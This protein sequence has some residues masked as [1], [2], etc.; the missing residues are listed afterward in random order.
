MVWLHVYTILALMTRGSALLDPFCDNTC[1]EFQDHFATLG[2]A[3]NTTLKQ[4]KKACRNEIKLVHPD[5]Q[6]GKSEEE[7]RKMNIRHLAVSEACQGL[8]THKRHDEVG[9]ETLSGSEVF[10]EKPLF[11]FFSLFRTPPSPE[12]FCFVLGVVRV[13]LS[14]CC[15][16]CSAPPFEDE[17]V[18]LLKLCRVC[19]KDRG[20][21]GGDGWD[22]MGGLGGLG[23]MV[24]IKPL[25][26]GCSSQMFHWSQGLHHLPDVNT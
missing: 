20:E 1:P 5:K 12:L 6:V 14:L 2:V 24:R 26:L 8:G 13:S 10:G 15:C 23:S 21:H 17:Y 18:A 25:L 7:R 19:A 11:G 3:D 22:P 16:F 4:I 9:D